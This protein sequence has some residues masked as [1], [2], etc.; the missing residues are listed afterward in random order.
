VIALQWQRTAK[1]N[2]GLKQLHVP[3]SGADIIVQKYY[4]KYF[5]TKV[6]KLK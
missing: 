5:A 3:I 4:L 2:A 6:L 1:I